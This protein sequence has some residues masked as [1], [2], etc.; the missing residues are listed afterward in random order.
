MSYVNN[1]QLPENLQRPFAE[2]AHDLSREALPAGIRSAQHV[3]CI[4]PIFFLRDS[5]KDWMASGV[6]CRVTAHPFF[7]K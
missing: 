4:R 1:D 5:L 7:S 3:T 2:C 6:G